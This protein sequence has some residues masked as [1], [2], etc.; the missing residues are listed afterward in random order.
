MGTSLWLLACLIAPTAAAERVVAVGDLHGDLDNALAVLQV[1]GVVDEQ[2]RWSGGK[3][4][5]V[6]TGDVTDRGPDSKELIELFARL[7]VEAAA[8]GGRVV[9]LNGNHEIMNLMGDLRY[10]DPGDTAKFASPEARAHAFSANG[11]LGQRLRELGVV[12]QV[13]DTVFTHGGVTPQYATLG[14]DQINALAA[15]SVAGEVPASALGPQ[16]PIWYRGYVQ[17]PEAQACAN[18]D[19]ALSQL[20]AKRMVVGHTTQRTG[21]VLSRCGGKLLVIDIGVADH[22]GGNLGAIELV[23]G[24]ARALYPGGPVDLP[25]PP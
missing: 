15:A 23:D 20:G 10:V 13:G 6:Q 24:D 2:G 12:A 18:L 7:E 14:I 5:L 16:S 19:T 1:A 21:R 25:D 17:D 11:A 8:I 22:Y 9:A 3:A 4:T